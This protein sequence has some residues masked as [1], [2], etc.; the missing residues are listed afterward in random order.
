MAALILALF[1]F[2]ALLTFRRKISP[3]KIVTLLILCG[4]V[5]RVGYMLYT[6]FYVRGHDVQTICQYGHMSYIFRLYEFQRLPRTMLGQNY[7]PPL[8]HILSAV[9]VKLYEIVSGSRHIDTLFEAAKL[10]PCI[11]SSALLI[12]CGRLFTE[13]NFSAGAKVIAM[14]VIAFHPT[15][16][17]LSS[18]INNDALM[19]FFVMAAFLYTVRW[20][21]EQTYK[22][23]L[24]VALFIGAAMST[25]FSGALIAFYTG[26]VFLMMLVKKWRDGKTS[27]LAEQYIAFAAVCFPLG[28]WHPVRNFLLLRQPFGYVP[29][30]PEDS[31]LYVGTRSFAARFLSFSFKS[32]FY[33]RFCN[34]FYQYRIWE[35]TVACSLF[36]EFTFSEEHRLYAAVLIAANLALISV[37]L[38]AMIYFLFHSKNKRFAVLSLFALWFFHVASFVFFNIKY[39]FG[40]TMDFRYMVPTVITGAAFLGLLYGELSQRRSA[41]AKT[42]SLAL[43]ILVSLFAVYS[44]AFYVI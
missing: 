4:L 18:S 6:P 35:Y 23:I 42:A 32:L 14:A 21:K 39:P 19:I 30:I 44:A 33:T 43:V 7:H 10:V 29:H 17:L 24:L 9:S 12:M 37:S 16:Y 11:A 41:L 27:A 3:E 40:C 28:L 25:K 5:M 31:S 34:P 1:I 8:A 2:A 13:L 26:L 15:F 20:Y 38:G 36:G 22:N